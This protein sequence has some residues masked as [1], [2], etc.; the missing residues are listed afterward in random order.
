M[1]NL[2]TR[3]SIEGKIE[4]KIH[5]PL[6]NLT[7]SDIIRRGSGLGLDY[8]LTW[9]CYDPVVEEGESGQKRYRPCRECDSCILREKGFRGAGIPDPLLG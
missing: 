9:S 4:F 1:A 8:S 5:T 6:I 7:K 3:V 2:A